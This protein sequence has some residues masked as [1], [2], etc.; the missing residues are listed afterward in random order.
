M[1][2]KLKFYYKVEKNC[3]IDLNTE[4]IGDDYIEIVAGSEDEFYRE[5]GDYKIEDQDI[6]SQLKEYFDDDNLSRSKEFFEIKHWVSN[7]SFGELIDMYASGEIKKPDMQREFVWDSL[8][9]SR[10][11]ES[12]ILGLPIPPLFLMES[13][14][15]VYEIIDGFQR[16]TTI[17][18]FVKGNPWYESPTS[19][20][21]FSSRLSNKLMI[22]DIK[23]KKFSE[24]DAE[25]QRTIKRS[26]IPLIEFKQL[27]P[28][29]S[30]SKY[31]IFE[32]INTGSEK[33]NSMQIRKALA[34]GQFVKDLYKY[35]NE[36]QKFKTLFSTTALRRDVHIEAFLRTI[37]MRDIYYGEYIN[38][39]T[40]INNILNE[41]CEKNIDKEISEEFYTEFA[42]AIDKAFEIFKNNEQK[43][44]RKV[45]KI[46]GGDF[47]IIGPVNTGILEAM[48]GIIM[49]KN[50]EKSDDKTYLDYGKKL[51]EIL[52]DSIEGKEDNPFSVSTGT[53][54]SI[55]QRF[56]ILE[57]ILGI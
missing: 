47:E 57:K 22:E 50:I 10:L 33:L 8:K 14:K 16:L 56:L 15:N 41:Y 40:G 6:L 20:R 21:K 13:G 2:E 37:V 31:L 17:F 5:I 38:E 4:C 48:V 12:I 35:G 51:Y 45:E 9:S 54:D 44:F 27:D 32:R 53:N 25:H 52:V 26:T 3:I 36:N 43:L 42:L 1:N 23:G 18:N 34:H 29:N 30:S 55:K 7:R 11:I 28:D 39:T 49:Y 19:V 24:L 46:R